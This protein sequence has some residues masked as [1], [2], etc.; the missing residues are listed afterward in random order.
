MNLYA[1]RY[2]GGDLIVYTLIENPTTG[3]HIYDEHGQLI[4]DEVIE[5]TDYGTP[6]YKLINSIDSYTTNPETGQ[7][8]S[9]EISGIRRIND[10]IE[11]MNFMFDR[12]TEDDIK[13][14]FISKFKH[15]GVTYTIKDAKAREDIVTKQDTL[16]S[17]TNIKTINNNSILGNGNIDVDSLPSQSGNSGKFLTTNGSTASWATVQ[18]GGD[19]LPDQTGQSGKFLTTNGSTASWADISQIT[20]R[21]W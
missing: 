3:T 9:I 10:G 17:G 11:L 13:D 8:Y 6:P 7:V 5:I 16:V 4:E 15:N 14:N 21:E 1:W 18:G 12:D 19:S 2:Y 20:I